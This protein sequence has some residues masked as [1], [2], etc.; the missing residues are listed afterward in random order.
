[1]I[2]II[3]MLNSLVSGDNQTP[4]HAHSSQPLSPEMFCSARV[5]PQQ[6]STKSQCGVGNKNNTKRNVSITQNS[7]EQ[8]GLPLYALGLVLVMLVALQRF[9]HTTSISEA[10]AVTPGWGIYGYDVAKL[11]GPSNVFSGVQITHSVTCYS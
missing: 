10:S 5:L 8:G 1:M 3:H 6:Q 7:T 11:T 4:L 9:L 2:F